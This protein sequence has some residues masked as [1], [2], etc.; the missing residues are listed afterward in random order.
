MDIA[1]DGK[2]VYTGSDDGTAHRWSLKK[3]IS[4]TNYFDLPVTVR[5]IAVSKR[6]FAAACSDGIIRVYNKISGRLYKQLKHNPSEEVLDVKITKDESKLVSASSD[7]T[8]LCFDLL[9]GKY[10][11]HSDVHFGWIWSICLYNDDQQIVTGS[12]D[13][14]IVFMT[15]GGDILARYYNLAG[16]Q[17]LISCPPEKDKIFPNGC[18]YTTN[19]KLITVFRNNKKNSSNEVLAEDDRDRLNY[20]NKVNRKNIV[21]S[22]LRN[23]KDYDKLSENYCKHKKLLD[24]LSDSKNIKLLRSKE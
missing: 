11:F 7:G 17:V 21:I 13:G 24:G 18:F 22:K 14:T 10:I 16:K 6:Y 20:L 1:Y 23:N 5:K 9:S 2:Y 8:I 15:I 12:T 19:N 4:L 3:Q